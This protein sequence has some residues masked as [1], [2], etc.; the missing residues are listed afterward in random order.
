MRLGHFDLNLLVALDALIETRS[1]TRASERLHIGVSATSSALGR[2]R[3]HFNDELLQQVGRRME[4]T[5]L[6]R[7]LAEP[8]RDVLL[9]TRATLQAKAGFEPDSEERAF[10][11]NASDYVTTVLITRLTRHLQGYAPKVRL[12][13]SSLG[14]RVLEQ[15]DRGG[16]DFAIFPEKYASPEHP[17]ELLFEESYSCVVWLGNSQVGEQLS[18]DDYMALRHVTVRFGPGHAAS[19]EEWSLQNDG[20]RRHVAAVAGSFNAQAQLV[21][22]TPWAATMQTRLA[23]WYAEFLPIR[24][25]PM[26][27]EIPALRMVMQWHRFQNKA[28]AHQ[29]MREQLRAVAA[30]MR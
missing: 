12:E 21:V 25:L 16:V 14:D 1:V 20:L 28:P 19:F 5:P 11:F 2:L 26:P 15:L 4:L 22:G 7:Q 18:L 8:V 30:S 6:A 29:W 10:V 3:E 9:R 27:V 24:V 13:L 17:S 23:R